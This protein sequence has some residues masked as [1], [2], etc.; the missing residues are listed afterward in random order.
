[1]ETQYLLAR[2]FEDALRR[3]ID[4]RQRAGRIDDDDTIAD[5]LNDRLRF[6][7]LDVLLQPTSATRVCLWHQT[8]LAATILDSKSHQD[9]ARG[10][11]RG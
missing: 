3:G 5:R 6:G 8:K 11:W 1:M 7:G 4:Q 10:C 9:R 2:P